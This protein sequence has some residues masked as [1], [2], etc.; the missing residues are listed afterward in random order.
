MPAGSRRAVP[1]VAMTVALLGAA[2]VM[3]S[4]ITSWTVVLAIFGIALF[5]PSAAIAVVWL[6]RNW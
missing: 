5:L 3:I 4:P 1:V 2:A 6:L